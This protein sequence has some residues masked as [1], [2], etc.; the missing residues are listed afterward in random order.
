M[1]VRSSDKL[2]NN[3]LTVVR[4]NPIERIVRGEQVP[5]TIFVSSACA[6]LF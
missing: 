5:R 1:G 2:S 3:R 6:Q 4:L